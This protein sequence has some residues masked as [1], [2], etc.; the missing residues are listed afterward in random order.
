MICIPKTVVSPIGVTPP[1]TGPEMPM[2]VPSAPEMPMPKPMPMPVPLP[3][4][5]G[6]VYTVKPGDTMFEIAR[7]YGISLADLIAAN[8]QISDPNLIYPGQMICIPKTIVSPIGVTPPEQ[9]PMPKPMPMPPCYHGIMPPLCP[10]PVFVVPWEECPY[11]PKKHKKG[12]K[13][14]KDYKEHK[15]H[16]EHHRRKEC[17]PGCR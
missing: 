12:C 10:M 17:Y 13:E 8:P 7:M 6:I 2:P 1:E 4:P 5:G 15:G 11:R 3:C 16:K 14:H 9:M